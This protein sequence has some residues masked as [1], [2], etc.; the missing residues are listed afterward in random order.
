MKTIKHIILVC[1][2]L[3]F[4][5]GC[6]DDFVEINTDPYQ[7]SDIE[8]SLIF[9]GSQRTGL[10]GWGGENTI[11]Q[12]YVNPYNTGATLGFNFNTIARGGDGL[13]GNYTGSVKEFVE[14]LDNMLGPDTDRIN[15][16]SIVRIWKAQLFMTM[17]D[18]HGDIPY[19]EA[20]KALQG[21]EF[22]FPSYDDQE[23]IYEDLRKEFK[24][25]IANLNPSGE[26]VE[27]DLFYGVNGSVPSTTAAE[28]VAKWQK[29]G[30]S[31]LLRLGMRYVKVNPTLAETIVNEAV[32]GPGG[33]MTSN[34]DN[35]FV[36]YD[37]SLYTNEAHNTLIAFPYF[38]YATEP[39][40]NQLQTT[41]DPRGKYLVAEFDDPN[42]PLGDEDPDYDIANQFGVPVSVTAIAM[43]TTGAPDFYR[44]TKGGGLNY[45]QMNVNCG[46]SILA[47]SF[48]VT[49]SQ[50]SFFLAEAV[51]RGYIAGDAQT[52][53]E[54][55][56][57]ANMDLYALYITDTGSALPE[58]SS[59][60]KTAY[61]ADP[62]VD[63][64][65]AATDQDKLDAISVQ[66]WIANI[67]NS[68]EAW[69]NMRRNNFT[70][71]TRN[72]FND[73]Y[74]ANGGDGFVHRYLYPDSE[75]TKNPVNYAAAVA[76]IGGSDDFVT[77][78]FWDVP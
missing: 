14:I 21:D 49:Y 5:V 24:E 41:N 43:E 6:D 75:L 74:L 22:Y 57:T 34:D 56:I 36:R 35:A 73:N 23:L 2:V 25:A 45:S 51:V 26:F 4:T 59:A 67:N 48:W 38:H 58:V 33:L 53:Y 13:F 44:G 11:V 71:L 70:N 60:E 42:D 46:A 50:T 66:F 29:L 7:V 30:N 39:F 78:V 15:L 28:Q 54:N 61:L 17:V 12:H 18:T 8:P 52:Y 19:F 55:A 27:A 3:L 9:A 68:R 72:T 69:A 10:G 63:F 64:A 1:T 31:L 77:R 47:P 32:N 16:Q 76:A 65:L 40:V 62:A 20:G 37:G